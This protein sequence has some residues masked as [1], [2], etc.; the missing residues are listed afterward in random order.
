[1]VGGTVNHRLFQTFCS[2]Y[3]EKI[4]SGKILGFVTQ[5]RQIY[6][7][8]Y[9]DD[10]AMQSSVLLSL[11]QLQQL[12]KLPPSEVKALLRKCGVIHFSEMPVYSGK[13]A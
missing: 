8:I 1:M 5:V 7:D 2:D 9:G 13:V 3:E 12:V 11:P 4:S 6:M 10:L